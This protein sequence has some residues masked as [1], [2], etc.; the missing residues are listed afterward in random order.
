[1]SG[2]ISLTVCP[3][4]WSQYKSDGDWVSWCVAVL[5]TNI[6]TKCK[7]PVFKLFESIWWVPT[8]YNIMYSVNLENQYVKVCIE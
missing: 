2:W 3:G 4:L 5:G 8:E 6:L 1:M 7:S